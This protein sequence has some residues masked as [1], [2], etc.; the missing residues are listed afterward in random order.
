MT[1]PHDKL[2]RIW[3]FGFIAL[4]LYAIVPHHISKSISNWLGVISK[5]VLHI[6]QQ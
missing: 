4:L 2:R 3:E 6:V 5:H 1:E